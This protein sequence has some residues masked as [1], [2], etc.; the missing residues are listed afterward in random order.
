MIPLSGAGAQAP[1]KAVHS[2]HRPLEM[3]QRLKDGHLSTWVVIQKWKTLTS[4]YVRGQQTFSVKGQVS[5]ISG[6]EDHIASVS[7]AVVAQKK[8]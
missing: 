4:V 7:S 3:S 6:F 2:F 8:P 1:A 5:N